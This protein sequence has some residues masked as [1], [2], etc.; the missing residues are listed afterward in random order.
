MWQSK[1]AIFHRDAKR[2]NIPLCF[3][4]FSNFSKNK[5]DKFTLSR[6]NK[7][8]LYLIITM[9]DIFDLS[10]L[11]ISE[12]LILLWYKQKALTFGCLWI[13]DQLTGSTVDAAGSRTTAENCYYI[14]FL[15]LPFLLQRV[16]ETIHRSSF[17]SDSTTLLILCGD[18]ANPS[19]VSCNIKKRKRGVKRKGSSNSW[20]LESTWISIS[21]FV[22]GPYKCNHW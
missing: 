19:F 18:D 10:L 9:G 20:G 8:F 17:K 15:L 21:F 7:V 14:I 12:E 2:L 6:T 16:L 1:F 11:L 22:G 3:F 4:C 5:W 13:H